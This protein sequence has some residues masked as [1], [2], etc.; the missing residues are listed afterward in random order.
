MRSRKLPAPA[1]ASAPPGPVATDR[2]ATAVEAA[3]SRRAA[4]TLRLYGHE[5]F[6]RGV[7]P[8]A[9]SFGTAQNDY[10]IGPGDELRITIHGSAHPSSRRYTV[11]TNGE[12]IVDDLRPLRAAGRTLADFRRQL[13]TEV[14]FGISDHEAFVSLDGMR[15]MRVLVTGA[16]AE[17]GRHE[18]A[19]SATVLDAL[20]A[21][22]GVDRLGSLRTIRLIRGGVSSTIDFY[23][24]LQG[25]EGSDPELRDGDRIVVP[26]IGPTIAVAGQVKR[27]GIYELPPDT[28]PGGTQPMTVGEAVALAGGPILPSATRVV[29]FSIG[30]DGIEEPLETTS[31]HMARD[32]GAGVASGDLLIVSAERDQRRG[33]VSIVGHVRQS[34]PRALD[35]AD[36]LASLLGSVDLMPGPYLPFAALETTGP[37]GFARILTPVDLRAVLDLRRD[38]PLADDDTLIVL[39]L[40][41]IGFLTSRPV[42]DL[43]RDGGSSREP[44]GCAGLEVLARRLSGDLD[45]PLVRGPLGRAAAELTPA[46]LPCP[47]VFDDH[48]DLLAFALEHAVLLRGGVA[49]PGLYPVVD[50]SEIA[51]VSQAAGGGARKLA[52]TSN[53]QSGGPRG[54]GGTAGLRGGDIVDSVAPR[55]EL[56]GHARHPGT[57]LLSDTP[58][59]RAVLGDGGQALSGLYPLF[60]V[61]ERYD[62]NRLAGRL[63]A[64]SPR[65]VFQGSA[66]R[67]LADGDVVRLFSFAEIRRSTAR[68]PTPPS[69][70]GTTVEPL[71]AGILAL[72][73][74]RA[75]EVRGAVR[76]PGAYPV[77]GLVGLDQ[78]I[79]IAGGIGDLADRDGIEI[80][81]REPATEP[82][83]M[84]N[85]RRMV[86]IDAANGRSAQVSAGDAIRVNP[87]F[88]DREPRAVTIDGEVRRPGNF[89]VTRGERLSS[90]L[91]R[92]G[93][94]TEQAYPA[95]AVFAR[96]SARRQQAETFGATARNIDHDIA[97][98][99]AM[100]N[101]P[102]AAEIELARQMATAF[103]DARPIGRITIEADPAILAL[104]PELDI[105]L[106]AGDHIHYPKRPLTVTVTVTGEVLAPASLQFTQWKNT[107][108]YL[109]EAGGTTRY[110]DAS[111]AF[112]LKPDGSAQRLRLSYWNHEY[113]AVAPGSTIIVPRDPE[114]FRFFQFTQNIG[115]LLSQLAVSAAAVMVLSDR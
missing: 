91:R 5:L 81:S 52:V 43:L 31:D 62:R 94:L 87:L 29:T 26:P 25:V 112:V 99:T 74:E 66:D 103:R 49:R 114:P 53:S 2:P 50:G 108:H 41:D 34:G 22:G 79:T 63:I 37:G 72:M 67:P 76:E 64:F 115:G 86:S 101:P 98:V 68:H 48:P 95:G 85:T 54:A 106:E 80:T 111:R 60:G 9:P 8:V 73:A 6:D 24:L 110:A 78:M 3:F 10:V 11:D 20:L 90:L 40:S 17:P 56:T 36:S 1:S 45:G 28:T 7:K 35:E 96:E 109:D 44:L 61:I 102:P 105:V 104:R 42:I 33:T 13:E 38:R 46:S 39:S 12:V 27:P 51:T 16:V 93:G 30:A 71:A 89:D 14:A 65:E 75:V 82:G 23:A 55:F 21:A 47:K 77:E 15:R 92:A 100:P 57:R 4:T 84:T 69:S 59:L 58:S 107:D 19:G 83:D 88:N 113:V 97:A 32:H 70:R 18:V